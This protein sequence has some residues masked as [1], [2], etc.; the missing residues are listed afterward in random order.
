MM[1]LIIDAHDAISIMMLFVL[2]LFKNH[3]VGF[4][5]RWLKYAQEAVAGTIVSTMSP[6][7]TEKLLRLRIK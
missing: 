3:I 6:C 2:D 5:T 7:I 1:L 4:A